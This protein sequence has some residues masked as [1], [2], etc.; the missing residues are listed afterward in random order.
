MSSRWQHK[1]VEI[2]YKL[3]ANHTERVQQELDKH[4]QQGW[5]LVAVVQSNAA[6]SIRLF[7]KKPA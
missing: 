3:F 1:V 2:A 6:D 7:F 4:G 5:E